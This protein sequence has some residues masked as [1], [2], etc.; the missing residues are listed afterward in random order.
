MLRRSTTARFSE[1]MHPTGLE[2]D[3]FKFHLRSMIKEGW[4][5]KTPEGTYQLSTRGKNFANNLNETERTVQRQPKLSVIIVA[6]R[7]TSDGTEQFLLH[8]RFRHPFYSF[9][10]FL[11]GPVQWGELPE[12]TAQYELAKQ[13][14][15]KASF[16]VS[17]IYRQRT[18]DKE[19]HDLLEDGLFTVMHTKHV[20]GELANEW[21][22]GKNAWM[23]KD[24][25][26]SLEPKFKD[27]AKT[28][29][30][31]EDP[32]QY[33]ERTIVYAPDEY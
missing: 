32:P 29:A 9:W 14:G 25:I 6:S 24:E 30:G 21:Q 27:T 22:G 1:L 31:L 3:N 13:T 7:R 12:E 5:I 18:Y 23:S 33:T 10:G 11:S 2:S 17:S 8:Q 28:L 19:T 26:Q 16:V 4:V 20:E 15:L